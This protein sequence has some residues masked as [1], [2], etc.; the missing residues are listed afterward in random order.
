MIS[1]LIPLLIWPFLNLQCTSDNAMKLTNTKVSNF[2]AFC[3]LSVDCGQTPGNVSRFP[4]DIPFRG[5]LSLSLT[6]LNLSQ[7]MGY[8][9]E[10]HIWIAFMFVFPL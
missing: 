10:S 9:L 8:V 5:F 7:P 2:V 3:A 4:F 6:Q 1:S